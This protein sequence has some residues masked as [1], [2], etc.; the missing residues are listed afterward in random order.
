MKQRTTRSAASAAAIS[1]A[2]TG[3][4]RSAPLAPTTAKRKSKPARGSLTAT[5][6]A[7]AL[8]LAPAATDRHLFHLGDLLVHGQF[9]ARPSA[10]NKS[11]YVGDVRLECGRVAIAHMPSMDMGGKCIPDAPLLLKTSVDAKTKK[12]VGSEALG[13]FGTPKCEF[14][15]QLL[16]CVEPENADLGGCWVGAHP[17][18]GEKAAHSLL[19]KGL[20]LDELGGVPIASIQREVTGVAG[21]DM[22]CD[23]LLTHTDKTKTVV[24]VKTVVDTDYDPT[25][26]PDRQGCVFVGKGDPYVRSAIFPWGRSNQVGPDG[27]KVVSARAIKHVR[28]LTSIATGEKRDL[29]D[30][31]KLHAAVLFVVVRRDAVTFRPNAEACPS[32]ARYLREARAAGVRV[33]ARRL[34][35]GEAEGEDLG[36]AI[37]DGNLPVELDQ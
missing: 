26:A 21:T 22:R 20:L 29:E 27:E 37:D 17:S 3:K 28:E 32:F 6:A 9:V 31:S 4:K 36:T 30:G 18:I 25:S 15:L 10:R 23:F 16:K 12:P 13:K 2:T 8:A 1:A 11:P 35:W 33:L 14:A 34:R 5:A 19:S 7:T 24:E